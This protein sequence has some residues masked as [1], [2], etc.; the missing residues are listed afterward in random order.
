MLVVLSGSLGSHMYMV[1]CP[2]SL[3]ASTAILTVFV[4]D[5]YWQAVKLWS[6]RDQ[7]DWDTRFDLDRGHG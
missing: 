1:Y 3:S 4:E 2:F 6:R 5:L 7:L